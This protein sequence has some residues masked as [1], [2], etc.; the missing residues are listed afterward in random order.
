MFWRPAHGF[1]RP[2]TLSLKDK[3]VGA[4]TQAIQ[5]SGAKQSVGEGNAPLGEVEVGCDDSGGLHTAFDNEV[6]EVLVVGWPICLRKIHRP[7]GARSK[8]F[9]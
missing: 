6:V 9:L 8:N 7:S 5:G 4:V 2:I 3:P 1:G